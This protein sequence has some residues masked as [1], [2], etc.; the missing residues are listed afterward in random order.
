MTCGKAQENVVYKFNA[1]TIFNYVS[2]QNN[3]KSI[4]SSN[5]NVAASTDAATGLLNI[6][7][8]L[9]QA[10]STLHMMPIYWAKFGPHAGNM[11]LNTQNE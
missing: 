8:K 10:C 7:V 1:I 9:N 4:H 6:D 5:Q 3:H 11:Q 2:Q